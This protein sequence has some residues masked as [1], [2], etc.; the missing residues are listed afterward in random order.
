MR[1]SLKY[2]IKAINPCLGITS[3]IK[4]HRRAAVVFA[5]HLECQY[6]L[7]IVQR[8]L[9]W[10][11]LGEVTQTF[12]LFSL[13]GWKKLLVKIYHHHHQLVDHQSLTV[14]MNLPL[15]FNFWSLCICMWR[16]SYS[17]GVPSLL[18]SL[19]PLLVF[20]LQ[21]VLNKEFVSKIFNRSEL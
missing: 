21:N 1:F 19:I 17:E 9:L 3:K 11:N 13:L 18:S 4:V 10:K 15:L 20:S 16:G 7:L 14:L 5:P 12:L 6:Q 2:G 8:R